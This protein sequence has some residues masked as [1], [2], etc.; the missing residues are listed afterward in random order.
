M[1]TESNKQAAKDGYEN[2]GK[3]DAEAAMAQISGTVV[4]VV[5]GDSALTGTYN[6]KEELGGLWGKLAEKGFQTRPDEF[7]A[8]GDKVMVMTTVSVA[9]EEDRTV[10][11]LSYDS[12][13]QLVRFESFGGDALLDKVFAK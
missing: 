5:G 10:D 4:W 12:D 11:V 8:E 9:G 13:G 7:L 6:G 1:S 3:G 2:F